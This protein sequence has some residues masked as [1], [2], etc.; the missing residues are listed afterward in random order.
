MVFYKSLPCGSESTVSLA[1]SPPPKTKSMAFV[2]VQVSTKY[3]IIINQKRQLTCMFIRLQYD[4]ERVIAMAR[5]VTVVREITSRACMLM[6]LEA[7]RLKFL[8]AKVT[9]HDF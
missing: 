9:L 4:V 3:N 5:V 7:L 8:I 2:P 1:R 6:Q